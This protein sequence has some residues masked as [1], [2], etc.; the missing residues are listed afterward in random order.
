MSNKFLENNKA[1]I[2]NNIMGLKI[3]EYLQTLSDY[4]EKIKKINGQLHFEYDGTY[5][6]LHSRNELKEAEKMLQ[7]IDEEKDYLLFIYGMGNLTLIRK[8]IKNTSEHTK[9]LL[10][11]EN[12]YVLQYY[13]HTEK[14]EDILENEKL[15]FAIGEE[16]I[17]KTTIQSCME[18]GWTSM[19]YNLKVV[20]LPNYHLY[21][22]ECKEKLKYLSQEIEAGIL[23]LGNDLNDMMDGV[24][25]NYL[26][27]D[28]CM[29]SNSLSE[30]RGKYKGIPGIVI[31]S[32][33][34]LDK[35]IQY[36]KEAMGKAV[37]IACDA[38]YQ[39]C[40]RH[41]VKPDAI[42][43]IERGIETYNYFYKGKT[44]EKDTVYVG[45]ALVW[46]DILN[47]FPGKKILLAKTEDGADGWWKKQFDTIEH[48]PMGMSCANVAHAVLKEA[49]CDPIILIGQ[50][51]AYTDGKKHSDE[52]HEA[53]GDSNKIAE[54]SKDELWTEGI[55]GGMVRT[56]ETFNWFRQYYERQSMEEKHLLVNATEGG[57][58]IHGTI[59]MTLKDAIQTYCIKEKTH[60]MYECLTDRQWD[61][62]KAKDKYEQIIKSASEVIQTVETLEKMMKEHVKHIAKYQEMD[63]SNFTKQELIQCVMDMQKGD[64]MIAYVTEENQDIATFYG[65]AY[66]NAIMYVKRIGNKLDAESVRKNY[67]I[68][69][70]LIFM[71]QIISKTVKEKFEELI[72]FMEK[73]NSKNG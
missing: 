1:L 45:P 2:K 35:N 5:Y 9:I 3:A 42:A 41:G 73:K 48:I 8:L 19:A 23:S 13:M 25:N 65:P 68:Q 53:F 43:S 27:V 26:N 7:N 63:F 29:L 51:L 21:H 50:D 56:T 59:E 52:A 12:P 72:G 15:V 34:S 58:R 36:L 31:A 67:E 61:E 4:T 60:N 37:M 30:I 11:E 10:V 32:G 71:M 70:R 24:T 49:G 28:Q 20:Q 62:Q 54:N 39:M 22:S 55:D 14:I 38:S 47:E 16:N 33:P 64:R 46:P 57:A 6:L 17:Y 40:L 66:K 18:L 69:V 44:I